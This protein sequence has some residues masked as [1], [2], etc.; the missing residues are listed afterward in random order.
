MKQK[1]IQQDNI[2]DGFYQQLLDN[3]Q[4]LVE[5]G[6]LNSESKEGNQLPDKD[7]NKKYTSALET[8]LVYK[9]IILPSQQKKQRVT[10][11]KQKKSSGISNNIEK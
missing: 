9:N 4:D 7:I 1:W 8:D 5:N 10:M 3:Y 11:P 6:Q 2:L